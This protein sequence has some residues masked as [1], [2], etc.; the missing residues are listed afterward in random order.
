MSKKIGML[1]ENVMGFKTEFSTLWQSRE[2]FKKVAQ[3]HDL[4]DTDVTVLVKTLSSE[5]AIGK[6]GRRDF[7]I[8]VGKERVIEAEF[9]GAKAQAFTDTPQEFRGKL[10]EAIGLS[11]LTN[12]GRAIFIAAM[13]AVLKHLHIIQATLHCRDNE[14]EQCAKEIAVHIKD[15][16]GAQKVG[17]IGLNP[18]ILESL[19]DTFGADNV[20]IT[21]LN[22]KNIGAVKYG[23]E[24]WDGDIM[25]EQL[26][27]NSDLILM[28]GTTFVNGTFDR[29]WKAIQLYQKRYLIYGVT[30]AGICELMGLNR[31]CLYGRA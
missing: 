23:V 16:Y 4:L 9:Q 25:A 11:L 1:K 10:R 18:A 14:P 12:G 27:E 13:N 31:I 22:R 30:S 5:E 24:V 21:D 17:L 20:K 8:V 28:T 29:I 7:P 3:S 6:P 15:K 2:R 26:V 19:C